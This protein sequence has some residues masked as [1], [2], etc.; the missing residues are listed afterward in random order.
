MRVLG[1][2][3]EATGLDTSASRIMEVGAVVWDV[4]NKSPLSLHSYLVKEDY[5]FPIPAEIKKLTGIYDGM[6]QEFGR[7]LEKVLTR[8]HEVIE[9]HG[10]SFIVAHN[11][12]NYDKPLL[13]SELSRLHTPLPLYLGIPWID[14]RQDLPWE[15][16]PD[17]RRLN[18]L[19][20]DAGFINPFPHRAIFD[21]LTMLKVMSRY[22]MADIINFQK[23]PYITVRAMVSYDERDK[24]KA[25]RFSWEKIGSENYPKCWVKKVKENQLLKEQELAKEKGF[26]VVRIQ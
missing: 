5:L 14:T 18:H 26:Q 25:Q 16:E 7:P 9:K 4:E 12:E 22:P 20:L 23:I 21:V 10:V 19:A 3:F 15:T 1:I 8:V 17:S 6:L 11:G 24:A 2:D 13:T